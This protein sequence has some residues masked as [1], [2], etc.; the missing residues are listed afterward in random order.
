MK[1]L[2][3]VQE[4]EHEELGIIHISEFRGEDEETIKNNFSIVMEIDYLEE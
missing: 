3:I 4:I 2:K 1:D